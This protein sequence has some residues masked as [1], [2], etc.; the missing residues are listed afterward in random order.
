ML[1]LVK[2]RQYWLVHRICLP[3]SRI[4]S[5]IGL[6]ARRRIPKHIVIYDKITLASSFLSTKRFQGRGATAGQCTAASAAAVSAGVCCKRQWESEVMT[7]TWSNVEVET[8]AG[9]PNRIAFPMLRKR[10]PWIAPTETGSLKW[11]GAR[12]LRRAHVCAVY[13]RWFSAP[14][15]ARALASNTRTERSNER[16]IAR[17][18]RPFPV[19]I[20]SRRV[21]PDQAHD[22]F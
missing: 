8:I 12:C 9:T 3:G 21:H 17:R 4:E 18:R 19:V 5:E 6:R 20:E 22:R 10:C 2:L 11:R 16:P 14:F 7:R 13:A 1:G 15:R